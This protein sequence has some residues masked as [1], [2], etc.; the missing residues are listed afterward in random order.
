MHYVKGDSEQVR[1]QRGRGWMIMQRQMR[2]FNG[3]EPELMQDE[4]NKFVCVT[5]R[6]TPS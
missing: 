3:T 5:F 4:R 1:E 6:L 2:D